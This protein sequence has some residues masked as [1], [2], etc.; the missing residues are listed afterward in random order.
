MMSRALKQEDERELSKLYEA[1]FNQPDLHDRVLVFDV[2]ASWPLSVSDVDEKNETSEA[3]GQS[4]DGDDGKPTEISNEA[5]DTNAGNENKAGSQDCKIETKDANGDQQ[6]GTNL[7]DSKE[8]TEEKEIAD[9]D[10]QETVANEDLNETSNGNEMQDQQESQISTDENDADLSLTNKE[11][12]EDSNEIFSEDNESFSTNESQVIRQHKFYIHSTWL[13]V[14]SSYFR[15]LFYSGMKES[16]VKE[17]HVQILANEEKAHLMLLEAM[18]KIDTLDNAILD[19]LLNVLK[20]AHKYDVKFVFRKCKYCLQTAIDS[21]EVCEK[22]MRFIKVDN[23]I[24]DV[25]DLAS[26]LRSF[27]AKEFSPLDKTWQTRSFEELCEPSV[28]YLLS[29]DELR[30]ESENTVFHALMY[31]IEQQ[32]TEHVLKAEGMP[33]ILSVVRFELIPIDYLYNIVQ[34]DSIAKT[35]P[36]FNHHY[37]RGISY[38]ALPSN[39]RKTLNNKPVKRGVKPVQTDVPVMVQP[40][41]YFTWSFTWVIPGDKLDTLIENEKELKSDEFWYCGYN[42]VLAISNVEKS[43]NYYTGNN[44]ERFIAKLSLQILNV[45][46]HSFVEISWNVASQAKNC[47][48][49]SGETRHTF[50]K[51]EQISSIDISYEIEVKKET[52]KPTPCTLS[53]PTTR[54]NFSPPVALPP[55]VVFD[56]KRSFLQ[57]TY[58]KKRITKVSSSTEFCFATPKPLEKTRAD[59]VPKQ[60]SPNTPSLS[61]DVHMKLV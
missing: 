49:Q 15:S 46:Q 35:F 60:E 23:T 25:E 32:G 12:V 16:N 36:D 21:L 28:R 55:T 13:A 17:V 41:P 26:T 44:S 40:T 6:I 50:K 27:L 48:S 42:M 5:T 18:Y 61:I 38:H 45:K 3:C 31:W 43:N 7:H 52:L 11:Q 53:S 39:I 57:P 54:F 10:K 47:R 33:S 56:S 14:Q 8:S 24:T 59:L 22:I 29:S 51:G 9:M 1:E 34:H 2:V 4:E 20:L 30:T 19:E 37:L 58:G